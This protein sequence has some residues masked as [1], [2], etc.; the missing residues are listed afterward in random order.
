MKFLVQE[1][2]NNKKFAEIVENVKEKIKNVKL[3]R[4]KD[5]KPKSTE[6]YTKNGKCNK[7]VI[8]L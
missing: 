5:Q 2:A 8:F 3:M 4:F 7:N 1:L 6:K